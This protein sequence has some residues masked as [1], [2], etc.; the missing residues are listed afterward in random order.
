[1]SEVN[2]NTEVAAAPV[3]KLED[4][5]ARRYFSP[6][7]IANGDAGVFL[8]GLDGA[9]T[10]AGIPIVKFASD[11]P[12]GYGLTIAA[13]QET[14]T[15]GEEKTRVTRGF[16]VWPMPSLALLLNDATGQ[17]FVTDCVNRE[18][19][20]QIVLPL[21]GKKSEELA[22][23]EADFLSEMPVELADF[24]EVSK[25]E[26]LLKS[27]NE[28]AQAALKALKEHKV[29][30]NLSAPLLRDCLS[31][32]KFA[33]SH[34]EAVEKKGFFVTVIESMK[35]QAT[36]KNLSTAIFDKWLAERN[37][38]EAISVDDLDGIDLTFDK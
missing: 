37:N 34:Y 4:L 31:N 17:A 36:A 16:A 19:G 26:G 14:V 24:V 25:R 20:T 2:T 12:A 6:E 11:L 5:P 38:A 1:M 33:E 7:E 10:A 29:F 13:V 3:I 9:A 21:R 30:K 22:S 23:A 32:A 28:L 8:E 15:K 27:Y 18:L 35:K